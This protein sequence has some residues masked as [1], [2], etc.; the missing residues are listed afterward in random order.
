[1]AFGTIGGTGH[2]EFGR[3]SS[4]ALLAPAVRAELAKLP[5][6][7]PFY[8][9][10]MLDHTFPFYAGHTTIMVARQDELSFG[11]SVEPDK[12]I[13]TVD[14]WIARWKQ[15]RY[16]LAIMPTGQYDALV[17][18]GVPMRLIARDNRRVIVEKPQ[19]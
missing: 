7:T 19:S 18:Q 17:K 2:D 1:L 5:A 15:E 11:I 6:D 8:S 10:E 4:G 16:A 9:I 13:P 14:Q 12:W 3:Y